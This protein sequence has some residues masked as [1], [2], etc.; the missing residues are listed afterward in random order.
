MQMHR[1][2]SRTACLCY[3]IFV[4]I[5]YGNT[6]SLYILDL[7]CT[8]SLLLALQFSVFGDSGAALLGAQGLPDIGL[9]AP[10]DFARIIREIVTV[11]SLPVLAGMLMHPQILVVCQLIVVHSASYIAGSSKCVV[12]QNTLLC[13]RL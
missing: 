11:T 2:P 9:G 3:W 6:L 7:V 13:F 1:L 10:T 5:C 8:L 12:F 4:C